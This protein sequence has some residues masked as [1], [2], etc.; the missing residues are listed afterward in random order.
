MENRSLN[1]VKKLNPESRDS[2]NPLKSEHLKKGIKPIMFC[3]GTPEQFGQ[4]FEDENEVIEDFPPLDANLHSS[5][6]YYEKPEKLKERKFR[7]AG[8]YTYVISSVDSSNKF[9]KSYANC[10]GLVVAGI[11]KETGK[12]ISFLSHQDPDYFLGGEGEQNHFSNE[13]REQLRVL[14]DKSVEGT[15]DAAIV[16]GNYFEDSSHYQRSYLDSVQF[17]SKAVQDVLGFEPVVMTGPKTEDMGSGR[18][19]VFYDN[20]NRRLYISRPS[21]G[22]DTTKSYLPSDIDDQRKKW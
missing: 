14:K 4:Y 1:L 22:D 13:L 16:G 5:V 10:T 21:V 3:V 15:I 9:S 6:D 18:D 7:N 19:D 20:N 12:N 8:H 17:L 2:K 11:D